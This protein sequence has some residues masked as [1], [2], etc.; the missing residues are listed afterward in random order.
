MSKLVK[1]LLIIL[2][3]TMLSCT[4]DRHFEEN[5]DFN[6][7]VWSMDEAVNFSFDIEDDSSYYQ[8]YFNLRNDGDYP[9]RNL[10]VHYALKDSNDYVLDKKL[11]DI[12]LFDPKSGAPYGEGFG[13]VRSHQ[14]LLEDSVLFPGEGKYTVSLRQYMRTDSLKGVHSAGI[15]IQKVNT[16][17]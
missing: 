17:E 16:A 10:Y 2:V 1:P 13:S 14:V 3:F 9:Y 8:L 7:R 15:R 11:Q 5:V 6:S 4:E 12:Q